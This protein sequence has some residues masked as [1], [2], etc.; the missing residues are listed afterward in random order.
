MASALQNVK[1]EL[2]PSESRWS[3]MGW[4]A[5]VTEPHPH[6]FSCSCF[7]GVLEIGKVALGRNLMSRLAWS[8][9]LAG[10]LWH[11]CPLWSCLY[12][13]L[14]T[15]CVW[16]TGI[17]FLFFPPLSCSSLPAPL[18]GLPESRRGAPWGLCLSALQGWQADSP[19]PNLTWP[20]KQ[21]LAEA[22]RTT[23]LGSKP[24]VPRSPVEHVFP[25]TFYL[26]SGSQKVVKN[27]AWCHRKE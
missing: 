4:I 3:W 27:P 2:V 21:L 11:L 14:W 20:W 16:L 24:Q 19:S 17:F 8:W 15:P 18:A 5:K 13:P 12:G 23:S 9:F 10:L 6:D 26:V 7:F 22:K 25:R 1:D